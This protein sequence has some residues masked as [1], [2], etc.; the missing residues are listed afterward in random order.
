MEYVRDRGSFVDLPF[1]EMLRVF[2]EI[3][4]A[5]EADPAERDAAFHGE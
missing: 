5:A 3:Y 1:D 2:R 4:R